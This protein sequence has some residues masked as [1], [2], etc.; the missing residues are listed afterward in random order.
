M[1]DHPNEFVIF[2]CQHFYQFANGDYRRFEKILL[3]IFQNKFYTRTDGNLSSLTLRKAEELKRQLIVIYRY[4]KVPDEFWNSD[5][6]P[7]PWPNQ[8]KVKKLE[9]VLDA[10]IKYRSPDA[11]FVSQCVLTPPV[12]FI[13]PR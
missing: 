11:G 12:K 9:A 6:W 8:I 4:A 10:N 2:D 1:D 7:T 13:V 5:S 3:K